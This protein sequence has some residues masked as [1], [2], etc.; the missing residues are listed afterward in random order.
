MSL[1]KKKTGKDSRNRKTTSK[2]QKCQRFLE[3]SVIVYRNKSPLVVKDLSYSPKQKYLN[4]K[5]RNSRIP[6]KIKKKGID[7]KQ[8]LEE[9]YKKYLDKIHMNNPFKNGKYKKRKIFGN[10]KK[11][12]TPFM[13]N[14]CNNLSNIL[15][16]SGIFRSHNRNHTT[17]IFITNTS[18]SINKV[19][20]QKEEKSIRQFE[21]K[22][23]MKDVFYSHYQRIK[24]KKFSISNRNDLFQSNNDSITNS[25]NNIQSIE[26]KKT[27]KKQDS[28][29]NISNYAKN[30]T[31]YVESKKFQK[32]LSINSL[33]SFKDIKESVLNEN[34]NFFQPFDL[35]CL[36]L[37]KKKNKE[38][39]TL[40][41]NKLRKKGFIFIQRKNKFLCTKSGIN[42]QIEIEKI[43]QDE[44]SP[45]NNDQNIF[46]LKISYKKDKSQ[47]ISLYS[48]IIHNPL[49]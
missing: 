18:D 26:L 38:N 7:E 27:N 3:S 24:H 40:F 20:K 19:N 45:D 5:T 46:L 29:I 16:N 47:I 14:K 42:F 9:V 30:D 23:L 13:K 44:N 48:D 32:N 41:A 4:E 11:K 17:N 25:I 39:H 21:P 37:C 12:T 10:N 36:F 34:N 43:K 49:I 2:K 6:W 1:Q 35:S 31:G 28:I 15:N 33:V 8:T 22:T